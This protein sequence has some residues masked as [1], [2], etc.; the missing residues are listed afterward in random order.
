VQQELLLF[1]QVY[2]L[3]LNIK[4]G[5]GRVLIT[6]YSGIKTL[7][8]K[9]RVE[10]LLTAQFTKVKLFKGIIRWDNFV[11]LSQW[12]GKIYKSLLY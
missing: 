10:R 9:D 12:T 11:E 3:L 5:K 2:I 6:N 7:S 1:V 4:K 8:T